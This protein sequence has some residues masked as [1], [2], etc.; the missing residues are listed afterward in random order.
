MIVDDENCSV[1]KK[2]ERVK[3]N[4]S[5]NKMNNSEVRDREDNSIRREIEKVR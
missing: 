1:K 4:I 5:K 2:Q 3:N